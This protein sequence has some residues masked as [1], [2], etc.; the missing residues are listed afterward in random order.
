MT[1]DLAGSIGYALVVAAL[2]LL[3]FGL[4]PSLLGLRNSSRKRDRAA[5]RQAAAFEKHLRNHTGRSTLTVD[6]M[7][8]EYLSQ[9]AL[10]DLAAVWGWRFR[11]DEPSAR[12]WLLHFNYEPDTPYEGPAA[13]LASELADADLN[14]DGM[15]VVDP[16]LYAALSDEE[17]DRVIA[18]AGWQRSPR[19]VVGMLALT[20][21]GTSVASGLGSINLGGVST[22]ELR[23]NP[24]M[25]ARAK[26]FETTHGFDPLDPYRLEHM[27]VR[28]NYWLKRFLPAAALCGLLWTVGVFP[29]LIGLEDGV[30]SKVFQVGA[31]MMLAGAACAVLAAWI[32]SRKRREIGAHMKE[33]QRMRRVYRRSTTSN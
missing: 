21:V 11:S 15:Y 14:A 17:R 13:R 30:D 10:R 27:R 2:V 33:L 32:N 26:A 9:P 31:W 6:W 25:L 29:L 18:V 4:F 16:T 3:P 24:D 23:Q 12:Q 22:A 7:D 5:P 19:P 8:Y 20:R 1:D 28:E